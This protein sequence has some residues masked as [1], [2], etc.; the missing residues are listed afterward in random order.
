[1]Q[2]KNSCGLDDGHR[3]IEKTMAAS[4]GG[5]NYRQVTQFREELRATYFLHVGTL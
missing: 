5:G 4:E 2:S 1:M 3:R